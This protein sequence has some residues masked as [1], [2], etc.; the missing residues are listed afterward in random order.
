MVK[1]KD[2]W[3]DM[4]KQLV[5]FHSANGNCD[6]PSTGRNKK[7]ALWTK[8]QREAYLADKLRIEQIDK[9]EDLDFKWSTTKRTQNDD[10]DGDHYVAPEDM[11]AGEK[12]YYLRPGKYVQYSGEGAMPAELI[13][14]VKHNHGELPPFMPLPNRKVYFDIFGNGQSTP[15]DGK[16]PLPENVLGYV[17]ENGVLPRNTTHARALK[18]GKDLY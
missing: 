9:L 6:V 13:D 8:K 12:L 1:E 18:E 7:L 3:T 15:W 5:K 4:Y 16:S 17:I 14:Y 2:T 10:S 11:F